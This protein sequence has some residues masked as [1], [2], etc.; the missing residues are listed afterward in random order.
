MPG[1]SDKIDYLRNMK[2]PDD[3][4]DTFILKDIPA[5]LK[6]H[7]ILSYEDTAMLMAAKPSFATK[8]P[9]K[10]QA[11]GCVWN[12]DITSSAPGYF[13]E[14]GNFILDKAQKV[15]TLWYVRRDG[16]IEGPLTEAEMKRLSENGGLAGTLVKRD[17]D[18]GFVPA[19]G[20]IAAIP[21]FYN[22]KGLNK[23]FSANQIIEERER[24]DDFYSNVVDKEGN[25]KLSNFMKSNNIT[26]SVKF[27]INAIKGMRKQEAIDAVKGI[28]GLERAENTILVELIVEKAETQ[29]L[30]D[31]D[32]DGFTIN[33]TIRAGKGRKKN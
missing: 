24:T 11:K 20:L 1:I 13:D 4:V 9:F 6:L 29:I 28:T 22:S 25:T 2:K 26:A 32:K 14:H 18:K 19:D 23:Y 16:A 12:V 15:S 3:L 5:P 27:I 30:S 10:K 33:Q 7:S 21:A 17:F 31:V 8:K